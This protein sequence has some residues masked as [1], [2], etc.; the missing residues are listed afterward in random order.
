MMGSMEKKIQ[1]REK[2]IKS[3]IQKSIFKKMLLRIHELKNKTL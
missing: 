3:V 1:E 2:L